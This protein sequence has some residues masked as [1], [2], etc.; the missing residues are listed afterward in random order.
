MVQNKG[1]FRFQQRQRRLFHGDRRR[2]G[3]DAFVRQCHI[4][5]RLIR[6]DIEQHC[7]VGQRDAPHIRIRGRRQIAVR[8][9]SGHLRAGRQS[10]RHDS[11]GGGRRQH[12]ALLAVADETKLIIGGRPDRQRHR[13]H[14]LR[15]RLVVRPFNFI[16]ITIAVGCDTDSPI[17]SLQR[18]QLE[19]PFD[20]DAGLRNERLIDNHFAQ[21]DDLAAK[22]LV[23]ALQGND[24][25]P[26][27]DGL[28]FPF[29]CDGPSNH[30]VASGHGFRR[31]GN[32][33]DRQ[34]RACPVVGALH[35]VDADVRTSA[36]FIWCAGIRH[37]QDIH[38]RFAPIIRC[39]GNESTLGIGGSVAR[40]DARRTRLQREIAVVGV[41]EERI[42]P[43]V[44]V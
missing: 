1:R 23:N 21:R 30:D 2:R 27:T 3:R 19:R 36:V 18:R 25:P 31:G 7:P 8:S 17:A 5:F 9:V 26:W 6:R 42:S 29:I 10:H 44:A 39:G 41:R 33:R 11:R 15:K 35:L 40:V 32:R 4:R 14:V 24:I 43:D 12:K 37:F 38:A 20:G 34:I 28:V 22:C 16:N 13:R